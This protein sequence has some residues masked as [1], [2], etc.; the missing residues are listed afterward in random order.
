MTALL[1]TGLPQ[2]EPLRNLQQF[3]EY[4]ANPDSF[5]KAQAEQL[6]KQNLKKAAKQ[7]A[8]EASVSRAAEIAATTRPQNTKNVLTRMGCR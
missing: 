3:E 6:E 7:R 1:F 4:Q 2:V 8:E 5:L